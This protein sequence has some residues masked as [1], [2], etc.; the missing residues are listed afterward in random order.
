MRCKHSNLEDFFREVDKR[1]KL[2][3]QERLFVKGYCS[4]PPNKK[5]T[6]KN[7]KK[8]KISV[9]PLEE[10]SL[11]QKSLRYLRQFKK[12][13]DNLEYIEKLMDKSK[14]RKKKLS[15]A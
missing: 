11:N 1:V 5:K 13:Q 14:I 8:R 2:A 3:V 6:V 7:K 4:S 12:S 15:V 10:T 9:K